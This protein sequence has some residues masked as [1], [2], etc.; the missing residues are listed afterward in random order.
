MLHLLNKN[1]EE[2]YRCPEVIANPNIEMLANMSRHMIEGAWEH[3]PEPIIIDK[4]RGWGKNMPAS[5][6]LFDKEIKKVFE[7][8]LNLLPNRTIEEYKKMI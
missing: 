3:R 7:D 6:I 1:Q 5:T 2:F 4:H 8:N